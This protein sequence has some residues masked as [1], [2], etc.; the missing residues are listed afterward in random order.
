MLSNH[1]Q[2][3]DNG[4]RQS[5]APIGQSSL[6]NVPLRRYE[7]DEAAALLQRLAVEHNARFNGGL[8]GE[9]NEEAEQSNN[10]RDNTHPG[11]ARRNRAQHEHQQSLES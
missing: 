9:G 10:R 7:L 4:R 11:A 6:A 8:R 3:S 5:F 2:D 1:H